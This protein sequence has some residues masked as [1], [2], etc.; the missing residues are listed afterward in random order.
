MTHRIIKAIQNNIENAFAPIK[1][2][3]LTIVTLEG[4]LEALNTVDE[5]VETIGYEEAYKCL[6]KLLREYINN[7]IDRNSM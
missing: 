7:L 3:D 4:V 5:L 2:H 6:A 1:H